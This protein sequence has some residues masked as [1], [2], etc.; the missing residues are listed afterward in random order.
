MQRMNSALHTYITFQLGQRRISQTAI[1]SVAGVTPAM[2]N[3]VIM[4]KR[5]SERVQAVLVRVL[6]FSSWTELLRAS[7]R[8]QDVVSKAMAREA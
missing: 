6:G 3:Y 4:D 1:A 8:F 5:R 7:Y 2:V